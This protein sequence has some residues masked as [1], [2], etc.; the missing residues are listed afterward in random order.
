MSALAQRI[1]T[2]IALLA[3]FLVAL[4][5]LPARAFALMLV[6]IL[7]LASHEWAKL[8]GLAAGASIAYAAVAAVIASVLLFAPW[9]QFGSGWPAPLVIAVCGVATAFWILV[10]PCWVLARWPTRARAPMLLVGLVTLPALW[11]AL[12]D[13]RAHSP[14]IVLGAMALVWIADTAAFFSGRRYG[15][16]KLAPM[17]SPGKTWEG[18]A[19]AL[20]AVALYAALLSEIAPRTSASRAPG[21]LVV[22]WVIV[23]VVLAAM[24]VVGDLFESW[25]KRGAGVKDSGALLPGHGGVLDRIDALLAAMPAAALAVDVLLR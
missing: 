1:A 23:A 12:V 11:L 7:V 20:V 5:L 17:V 9:A 10:A 13:M 15:R 19:G 18:V 22:A 14:L 8:V 25:L 24:S 6:G 3:V 16:H 21:S 2:A 4:F